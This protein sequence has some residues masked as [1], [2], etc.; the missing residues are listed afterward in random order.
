M[1]TRSKKNERKTYQTSIRYFP[2][3][4]IQLCTSLLHFVD[5][6]IQVKVTYCIKFV[7]STVFSAMAKKKRERNGVLYV[8]RVYITTVVNGILNM[9]F[10]CIL[11]EKIF[12]FIV[13]VSKVISARMFQP[14]AIRQN[15]LY[16]SGLYIQSLILINNVSCTWNIYL[17]IVVILIKVVIL[18]FML[19]FFF[20]FIL[21]IIN[22][23]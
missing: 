13:C 10:K 14:G 20:F 16:V 17:L 22:D 23:I 2:F 4:P 21:L 11:Q 18:L 6:E 12:A 8:C 15:V 3:L 19:N 9:R 7:Y 5:T 1:W